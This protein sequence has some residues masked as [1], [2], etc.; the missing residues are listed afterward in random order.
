MV[1][2]A[3]E[4]GMGI[5]SF[6]MFVVSSVRIPGFSWPWCSWVL[7]LNTS[8]SSPANRNMMNSPQRMAM[9][10]VVLMGPAMRR[11]TMTIIM[12]AMMKAKRSDIL[13]VGCFVGVG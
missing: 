12:T 1:D 7:L 9:I 10:A 6:L 11:M 3:M 2:L 4:V 13:A 5:P 8:D